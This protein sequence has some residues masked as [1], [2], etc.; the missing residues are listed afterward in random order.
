MDEITKQKIV[1]LAQSVRQDNGYLHQNVDVVKIANNSGFKVFRLKSDQKIKGLIIGE[2]KTNTNIIAFRQD[3]G[4]KD[5]RFII[6]HE[7]GHF[8]LHKSEKD[9]LKNGVFYYTYHDISQKE[10]DDEQEADLFAATLLVPEDEFRKK[11]D[12]LGTL[13]N[14]DLGAEALANYFNVNVECIKQ[15]AKELNV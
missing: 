8:F 1:N 12:E 6:A 13:R 15:R 7:L 4:E 10:I 14:T 11:W 9:Y 5:N 3:L 2:P